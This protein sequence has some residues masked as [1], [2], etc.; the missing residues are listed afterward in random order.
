MTATIHAAQAGHPAAAIARAMGGITAAKSTIVQ[1]REK[2]RV[3]QSEERM[4]N[5]RDGSVVGVCQGFNHRCLSHKNVYTSDDL[6]LAVVAE[7]GLNTHGRSYMQ[8]P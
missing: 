4:R 6:A 2:M 7:H 5:H 8:D 1:A 3:Q